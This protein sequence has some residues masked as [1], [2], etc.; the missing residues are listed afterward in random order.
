MAHIPCNSRFLYSA[1]S[2]F[3]SRDTMAFLRA[4]AYR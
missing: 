3:T 2:R 1:L 4:A